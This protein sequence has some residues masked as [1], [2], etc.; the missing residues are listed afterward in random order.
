MLIIH[1]LDDKLIKYDHGVDLL[2]NC[3]DTVSHIKLSEKMTHN[4]FDVDYDIVDPILE[5]F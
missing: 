3:K 5:F 1:G 2:S 4:D